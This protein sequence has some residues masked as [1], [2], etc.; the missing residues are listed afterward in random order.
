[1]SGK[2]RAGRRRFT[3]DS[4]F[5]DTSPRAAGVRE[6]V[7]AKEI[8]VDRIVPDPNQPRQTFDDDALAELATS[9][10]LEG[11]LQPIA[12]R[13][14]EQSDQYVIV[15][16]ERRWRAAKLASLRVVPAIVRDVPEERRLIQQLMENVVR[17]DLNAVDRAAAL[18]LLKR[19]MDDGPWERVA[20]A[21]G[22]RR[23]RLFQLLST[24]KLAEP[25]QDLIRSGQLSEKQTRPLQGLSPEAQSILAER[26]V[27]GSSDA[28]VIKRVASTLR[29][30]DAY[31]EDEPAEL[32]SRID[33]L[34]D[35]I[36]AGAAEPTRAHPSQ[37]VSALSDLFDDIDVPD[38]PG[39]AV[40]FV[41]NHVPGNSTDDWRSDI[42]RLG[43]RLSRLST[44]TELGDDVPPSIRELRALRKL[45]DAALDAQRKTR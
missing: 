8:D 28:T 45:I 26:I 44:E 37:V 43:A 24:E 30:D 15:H 11:L 16:G 6:L 14:D 34:H 10:R 39:A 2:K 9:I 36:L 19:Q 40:E 7:E 18:R 3:V 32:E 29:S 42:R 4:L 21:V 13:Y 38:D 1:M 33:V 27:A 20:E 22:I 35:E 41:Q 17:E 25:V 31:L 12:V 5:Q 23:S